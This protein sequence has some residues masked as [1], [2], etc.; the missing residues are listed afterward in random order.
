MLALDVRVVM[1]SAKPVKAVDA[2]AMNFE[3]GR[4]PAITVPLANAFSH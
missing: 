1:L 4:E 2:T 3:S